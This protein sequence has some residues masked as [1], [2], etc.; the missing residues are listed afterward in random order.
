MRVAFLSNWALENFGTE[1]YERGIEALTSSTL[2][3]M[4]KKKTK[5]KPKKNE[6]DIKALESN[7]ES[8]Q[9]EKPLRP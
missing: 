3:E 5:P 6:E 8:D 9:D 7:S 1:C 2:I 4:L